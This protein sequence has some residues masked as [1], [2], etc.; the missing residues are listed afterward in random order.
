MEYEYGKLASEIE[1][2]IDKNKKNYDPLAEYAAQFTDNGLT[3]EMLESMPD[4]S[5][6]YSY[7]AMASLAASSA[8]ESVYGEAPSSASASSNSITDIAPNDSYRDA[9]NEDICGGAILLGEL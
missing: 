4:Y 5:E 9:N 7:E 6:A 1:T 8:F 2:V 3:A